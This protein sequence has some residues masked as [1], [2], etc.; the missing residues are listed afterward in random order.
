ME[1]VHHFRAISGAISHPLG[2]N[3]MRTKEEIQLAISKLL[4]E[5]R[6]KNGYSKTKMAEKLGIDKH[7]WCRWESGASVPP[8]A[9]L[10][11]IFD[12][13]GESMLVPILDLLYPDSSAHIADADMQIERV[14]KDI[15][16]SVMNGMSDHHARIIHYMINGN[17]GSD[18]KAQIEEMCM[19][20]HLPIH[21]RFFIANQ[22]YVY[23]MM[24]RKQRELIDT[25]SVM[26]D[27][28]AFTYGL[29]RGQR[30]AYD[31]L[32]GGDA[33]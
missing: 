29:K 31:K 27:M 10:V 8:I 16:T 22:V 32:Q 2:G 26:P 15:V 9:D 14:K 11:M 3:S 13:M 28:D 25:E 5:I 17:H 20:E 1:D 12:A 6:E 24:A 30:A 21:Y 7:T 18:L 23:Y 4:T 19:I 33:K